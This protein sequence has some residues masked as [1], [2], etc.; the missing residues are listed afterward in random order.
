MNGSA[1][2]PWHLWRSPFAGA[3]NVSGGTLVVD[4]DIS[5]A[6]GFTVNRA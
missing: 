4:K 6:N 2:G 1:P 5:A 3:V